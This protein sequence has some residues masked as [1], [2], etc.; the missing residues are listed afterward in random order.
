MRKQGKACSREL[1][2]HIEQLRA[3]LRAEYGCDYSFS[4]MGRG[5][6]LAGSNAK[7]GE[8]EAIPAEESC[9]SGSTSR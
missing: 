8:I 7:D 2:T 1:A 5:Y 9:V 4:I 3:K 6:V